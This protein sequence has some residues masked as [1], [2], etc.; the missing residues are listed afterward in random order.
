MY[1]KEKLFREVFVTF[2][3]KR[4]KC[5]YILISYEWNKKSNHLN[6]NLFEKKTAVHG[7]TEIVE[8]LKKD[9]FKIKSKIEL[10]VYKFL[11]QKRH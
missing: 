11:F 8:I 4:Y 5:I 3:V 2:T 10:L 1:L 9:F 6:H 7:T